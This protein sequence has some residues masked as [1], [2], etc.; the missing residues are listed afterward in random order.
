MREAFAAGRSAAPEEI[1]DEVEVV[2]GVFGGM[3]DE[4]EAAGFEPGGVS[5]DGLFA[6]AAAADPEFEPAL[7]RL[8]EFSAEECGG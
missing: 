7:E 1:A 3:L 8:D 6:E 5:P 4:L 2:S